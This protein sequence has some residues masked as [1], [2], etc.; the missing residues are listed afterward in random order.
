MLVI[1]MSENAKTLSVENIGELKI[2]SINRPE[3]LNALNM[4]VLNDLEQELNKLYGDESVRVL[5]LTGTGSK[6][7]VAGADIKSMVKMSPMEGRSFMKKAHAVMNKIQ[8]IEK[9]VIAAINGFCLGGGL[10]LAMACDIRYASVN[11]KLGLPE[12]TL[13]IHPGFGGT[14]RLARIIGQG[15]ASEMI[16]TGK[17][18]DANEAYRI[19]LVQRV[20]TS[21]TLMNEVKNLAASIIQNGPIAIKLAKCSLNQG[22]ATDFKTG[23]N[24]EIESVA[25]TFATEDLKEGMNAFIEKRKPLFKNK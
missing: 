14:Q 24:Y 19:G 25:Q 18:L 22:L 13:G 16:F 2:I 11:A 1:I 7:F 8:Y 15:K 6:S 23:L 21:E 10:E 17:F 20:V 5:I 9:P 12:V 3:S 4:E